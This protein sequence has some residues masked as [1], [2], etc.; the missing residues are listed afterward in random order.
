LKT[1][2]VYL[3]AL[4]VCNMAQLVLSVPVLVLPAI[5]QVKIVN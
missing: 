1:L 4:C 3:M 2:L 5:E